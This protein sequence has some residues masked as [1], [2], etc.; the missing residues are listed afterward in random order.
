MERRFVRR[1]DVNWRHI[2][3]SGALWAVV[4]NF[5]WGSAWF[6]FMRREWLDAV[7]ALGQPLPWTAEVWFVWV[8]FTFP[9]GTAVMA[10]AASRD[11]S[12]RRA[13]A[14]SVM[15]WALFALGMVVWGGQQSLS[16]RVLALDCLVNLVAM[17]SASVIGAW[18]LGPVHPGDATGGAHIA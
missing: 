10:H 18:S 7:A 1:R 12:P 4:Y 5:T 2:V 9:I 3:A 17:V 11:V 15:V 16:A 8:T 6:A 13:M 14:A